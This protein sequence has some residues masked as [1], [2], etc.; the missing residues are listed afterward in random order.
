MKKINRPGAVLLSAALCASLFAGCGSAPAETTAA[1]V[2]QTTASEPAVPET[3]VPEPTVP[4]TTA[5]VPTVPTQPTVQLF[6]DG[7]PVELTYSSGAGGWRT[8][9]TLNADG[10]FTGSYTDSELGETG[11][12]Y[13]GGTLYYCNFSGVFTDVTV[14]D[15]VS[16]SLRLEQLHYEVP[17]GTVEIESEIRYVAADALGLSDGT[18]FRLYA[19][20]A[21]CDVLNEFATYAWPGNFQAPVP[22]TLSCW[23]LYNEQEETTFFSYE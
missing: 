5:A 2:P 3:T 9:L 4:E 10:T 15:E 20:D 22:D 11:K 8:V 12:D 19:P 17:T 1:T 14:L 6:A 18:D 21:P 23:A 7:S 13:P 16:F